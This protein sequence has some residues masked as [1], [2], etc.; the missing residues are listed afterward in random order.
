MAAEDALHDRWAQLRDSD[1]SVEVTACG[2]REHE[3]DLAEFRAHHLP[4]PHSYSTWPQHDSHHLWRWCRALDRGGRLMT[5]FSIELSASRALPGSFIGRAARVGRSLH[6]SC[7]YDPGVILRQVARAVPRLRRLDVQIFDEDPARR[8]AIEA[9]L[10]SAGANHNLSPMMYTRT[11][12]LEVLEDEQA[13]LRSLSAN[14]RPKMLAL[15]R[16]RIGW[17]AEIRDAAYIDRLLAIHRQ[18][19][20]RTGMGVPHIDFRDILS[21]STSGQ[22]SVFVGAFLAGRPSPDHLIAFAWGRLHGDY[23]EYNAAGSERSDDLKGVAPGYAMIGHIARWARSNGASWIDLGGVIAPDALHDHPFH[24]ISTF[25]RRLSSKELD[26]GAEYRI[27]PR[28]V[29]ARMASITRRLAI[30][31]GAVR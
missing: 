13:L 31:V 16:K 7:G 29:L 25:K 17:T 30:K 12:A 14:S 19:F 8:A 24:G 21:D 9:S 10:L 1:F 26:I 3:A 5:A 15:E 22:A 20:E 27:E 2:S 4:V 18:T 28:P 23:V 6:A 11:V